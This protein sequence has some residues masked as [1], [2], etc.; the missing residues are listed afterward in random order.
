M[1]I[2]N[3]FLFSIYTI[4]I[5]SNFFIETQTI[6]EIWKSMHINSLIGFQKVIEKLNSKSNVDFEIWYSIILPILETPILLT[7][8]LLITL[9]FLFY[10]FK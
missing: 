9:S 3:I 5:L 6:G 8:T 2:I 4:L 10:K 7:I 1:V